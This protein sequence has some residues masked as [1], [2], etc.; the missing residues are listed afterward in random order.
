MTTRKPKR[1]SILFILPSLYPGG[2]ERVIS[3]ISENLNKTIFEPKILVVYPQKENEYNIKDVLCTYLNKNRTLKAI[4]GIIRYIRKEKPNIV[5]T[6]IGQLNSLA[7]YLNLIF[8][9][10]QFIGSEHSVKYYR[11]NNKPKFLTKSSYKKL[12]KIICVSKDSINDF[13]NNYN[14]KKEKLELIPNPI[15]EVRETF[16][17]RERTDKIPQLITIGR[18]VP[19][20]GYQRILDVIATL[21]YDFHYTIIGDGPEKKNIY[22][23]INY[24]NLNNKVTHIP[25]TNNVIKYL[26]NSDVFL[27]GSY[28][29]GFGVALLEGISVGL[30]AVIFEAP[31][32]SKEVVINGV[33]GFVVK[34]SENFKVKLKETLFRKKWDREKIIDSAYSRY[35]L[36]SVVKKYEN[37]FLTI[38]E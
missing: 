30:P 3:V 31:G 2:A 21:N 18:L 1:Y 22:E 17:D 26:K 10:T 5:L 35:S 4:P 16:V 9:N 14:L 20:K 24:L 34:D 37:L 33:N 29:E 13:V 25:Y 27:Q 8:K 12:T 19:V 36:E 11:E 15:Y 7:G 28:V 6:T 23:K 38:L 32:G